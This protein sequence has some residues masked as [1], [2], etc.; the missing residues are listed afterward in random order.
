MGFNPEISCKTLEK[1]KNNLSE[2]I[3]FLINEE[4]NENKNGSISSRN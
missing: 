4:M 3:S 2:T 1:Y